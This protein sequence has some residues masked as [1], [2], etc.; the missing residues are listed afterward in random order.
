MN[1]VEAKKLFEQGV[2]ITNEGWSVTEAIL[3]CGDIA[4]LM[5]GSSSSVAGK[6]HKCPKQ[7]IDDIC[8]KADNGYSVAEFE[9]TL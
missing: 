7:N 4:L 1:K 6:Y 9:V 5:E 3:K 2:P 8:F